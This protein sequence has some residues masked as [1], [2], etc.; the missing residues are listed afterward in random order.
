LSVV[1]EESSEG[2]SLAHS[3][4]TSIPINDLSAFLHKADSLSPLSYLQKLNPP[5]SH[6]EN[7]P[8]DKIGDSV[9]K[10]ANLVMIIIHKFYSSS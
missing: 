7:L 5:L 6:F 10:L 8:Y 1:A 2:N 9:G 4:D 3:E